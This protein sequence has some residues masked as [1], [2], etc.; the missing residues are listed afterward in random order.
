[1]GESA[2]DRQTGDRLV[3]LVQVGEQARAQAAG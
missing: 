1:M 3:A 2:E